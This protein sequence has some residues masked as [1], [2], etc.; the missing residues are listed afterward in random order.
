MTAK[1]DAAKRTGILARLRKDQS[2]NTVAI[3]A[4]AL[5]PM[6]GLVGGAV[7]MARLYSVKNRLQAGCDA[8]SLAARK[9]MGNGRWDVNNDGDRF[10]DATFLGGLQMFDFNYENGYLGSENR[11][12]NF[13]EANGTV[14]GTASADVPMTLMRI[15]GE[16]ER[17][18]TV[19][20]TSQMKI[21]HTDVMFVFDVTGSMSSAI[22]G[23]PTGLSKINGLKRATK[24]FYEALG[25]QNIDDVA[26][27]DCYKTS[28]PIGDLSTLTQLRFGF[29]PFDE[30]V[31]I[32]NILQNG[33]YKN[34]QT[35]QSRQADLEDVW[36]WTLG[37]A[38]ATTGWL[39][40]WSP[41]SPS[42]TP[43]HT[44]QS[45]SGW[46]DVTSNTTTLQGT[47]PFRQTTATS[48]TSCNTFNNLP[49]SGSNLTALTESGGSTTT[50]AVGITNNPPVY[51]ASEQVT[52]YQQTRPFTVTQYR[53]IWES[54]SGVTGCFL[55][56]RA[57]TTPYTKTQTGGTSSRPI[58]WLQRQRITG[59]VYKPV[60]FNVSS[61]KN[62]GGDD[63]STAYNGSIALP[64][65][66]STISVNL[67]GNSSASNIRI[68][69]N[70]TVNW[71]G[72]I[73][74]RQTVRNDDGDP[75]DEYNPI[76]ED[77]Y[78]LDIDLIPSTG[79]EAT[80]WGFQLQNAVWGRH[81]NVGFDPD[82]D[83][84]FDYFEPVT[85]DVW[86]A[87]T[88]SSNPSG[89]SR[90]TSPGCPTAAAR[91]LAT[92]R[93]A[94][95]A[96]NYKNYVN[97]LTPGGNTYH[98]IGLIWGARLMSPTGIFGD[99]NATTPD[100]QEIQRHMIFMTDG[101][102]YNM[103]HN[104]TP[105]GI[106]GWDRRRTP[107]GTNP[108]MGDLNG[109]TDARTTALCTAIKNLG[110]NGVTLWVVYY[111][112]TDVATTN[113]MKNCAT[114]QNNHFFQAS[115]TQLLIESFN[116]I[117]ESISELKLTG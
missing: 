95:G 102:T 109:A 60:T 59:W 47:K 68:L 91:K 85:A 105:Y 38:S 8:G 77:A 27:A 74:E 86:R 52:T 73:E 2:G 69:S 40:N 22:P 108:D 16:E 93:D 31:N 1:T 26:P 88:S 98:D 18:V 5:F 13:L 87:T 20:C 71:T 3:F 56:R 9:I 75:S 36:T 66:E 84:D 104:Y 78:D 15:L 90:N 97:A 101:E 54:R 45:T 6:A 24:C 81:N 46:T 7:D 82:S 50:T 42:T 49:S 14:T 51:P 79:D 4:A 100:G 34:T 48:S 17:T 28:N 112:T 61:L 114:S 58:T 37:T 117:A 10:N 62:G 115:N 107:V 55:E 12:R 43:Y 116:K 23:D 94:S 64:L 33:Y 89:M 39:N 113:R 67:S 19:T 103:G 76:P 110:N 30:Q 44:R 57:H 29:V 92:Y 25:R 32:G 65:N 106:E 96:T 70:A 83:G 41:A 72:C 80:R 111:G 63:T 11:T 21:P 99:E 35:F 53:Y